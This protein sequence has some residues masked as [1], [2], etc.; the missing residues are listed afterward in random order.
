[1]NLVIVESPTKAKTISKFLGKDFVI[2]ASIGHVRDLP[3]SKLGVDI[4]NNF[5][6]KYEISKDKTK[7]VK[8]L[9][10]LAKEADKIYF[11][12]D[13]DREGEAI[14][15]HLAYIL[16]IPNN[17]VQRITFHEITKTA[18]LNALENP[19]KIDTNLV[20]AQQARRV[21]DRLVGYELSPFLWKK[22]YYGLSAG[23][24]QSVAVRLIVEREEERNKFQKEEYW[25]IESEFSTSKK[26]KLT[27][28]LVKI[29]NKKIDKFYINNEEQAKSIKEDLENFDFKVV[30]IEE[31]NSKKSV[32]FPFTTSTMQQEAANK[33]GFT[34][35]NTMR[36]AQ[37]LYE[38]INIG[39]DGQVGLITYMRT[40]SVNLSDFF[41][42]QAKEYIIE[43]FGKEYYNGSFRVFKTKSK[44]AQEAHEAIRPTHVN[45]AP[46]NI[47]S[48]LTSEQYKLYKLIWDRSVATQMKDAESKTVSY[49]IEDDK[50]TYGFRVSGSTIIFDGFMKVY[51]KAGADNIL[52]KVE[53][54]EKL[55]LGKIATD[56]HFT[57]PP[58]RYN[59]AS[60]IKA[61]EE[62]GIGRPSTYASITST[63][64]ERKYV[65]K[66]ES[67]RYYPTDTGILVNK[68]LCEHFP[69][70]VDVNFTAKMED[71][72]DEI[73]NGEK[74]WRPF[75]KDFYVPF[76]KNLDM[77]DK[78]LDKKALTEEETD[79]KCE[80]CGSPMVIK[81][82]RFGKFY[83]CSNYPTC[84]NTKEINGSGEKEPEQV[85]DE[86]CEKCGSPMVVKRGRYGT[87]I[88]CSNYPTCKNI[89]GSNNGTGVKCPQ[90]GK[91]EL[92]QK[93]S[94]FGFFY[95]CSEYPN[96]KFILSN[97]P[98]PSE[99]D[100]TIVARCKKC[101]SPLVY[102]GK[103][104]KIK[105]SNK[106]CPDSNSRKVKKD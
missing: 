89:K 29:N 92:M 49:D 52:P 16:N 97:K 10:Q 27:A 91:G 65:E 57:E 24:V 35:K 20:D 99:E 44:M 13:E 37:Q 102:Y 103:D 11:A 14:T 87:F 79:E 48:F 72:F 84:K 7:V 38:G 60:L 25:T 61:L 55:K 82:G 90:C 81:Y 33:L 17:E 98:V 93:R 43:N 50:Q 66:D 74:E 62:N 69:E 96:C 12:T 26:E 21:L 106:E 56:Q 67:K 39:K 88:A 53:V 104:N 19:R 41:M 31:K 63:I 86:K 70:I 100:A 78:E 8:E 23:R 94:R 83:A 80:K 77:K 95:S 30:N 34:A 5:E 75:I 71:G 59:D 42:M 1:M 18:I 2:K 36:I 15:W 73:A 40:D 85:L 9:K 4:E 28:E 54:D 51:Q 58:A 101:G 22:V 32:P 64:L 105:C 68:I 3:K 46:D 6:P 47:K 45:Y 76:K